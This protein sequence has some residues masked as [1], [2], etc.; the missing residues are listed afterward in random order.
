MKY[1]SH[2]APEH[3][4]SLSCCAFRSVI[5]I[6]LI[7]RVGPLV[8]PWAPEGDADLLRSHWCAASLAAVS[9][10]NRTA[11]LFVKEVRSSNFSLTFIICFHF[12]SPWLH[13]KIC[14]PAHN[15][16]KNS[17]THQ[18]IR[19]SLNVF[20]RRGRTFGPQTATPCLAS[21]SHF[22]VD[23]RRATQM[24]IIYSSEKGLIFSP[25]NNVAP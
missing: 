19:M 11:S 25:F 1:K 20:M 17:M 22:H 2:A 15:Q 7:S 24:K 18:S 12:L 21:I 4:R 5:C 3:V 14:S 16:T 6:C 23:A 10:N 8:I 13:F 9:Q